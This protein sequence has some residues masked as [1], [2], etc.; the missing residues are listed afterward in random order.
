M[1]SARPVE[2]S[3][4]TALKKHGLAPSATASVERNRGRQSKAVETIS[5]T[6]PQRW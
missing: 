6:N 2:A 4:T 3:R 5:K 1:V